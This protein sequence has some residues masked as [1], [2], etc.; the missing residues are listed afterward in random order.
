MQGD[1][2]GESAPNPKASSLGSLIQQAQDLVQKHEEIAKAHSEKPKS[3]WLKVGFSNWLAILGITISLGSVLLAL[4]PGKELLI[5]QYAPDRFSF[6][7]TNQAG[8]TVTVAGRQNSQFFIY[9]VEIANTGGVAISRDDFKDG[10]LFLV[11]DTASKVTTTDPLLLTFVRQNN[12]RQRNDTARITKDN[13]GREGLEYVPQIIN[14]G[15]HVTFDIYS[16]SSE[17][18]F[19]TE[20][21]IVDGKIR[22]DLKLKGP[23]SRPSP[24]FAWI[25]TNIAARRGLALL[26]G[27]GFML[28]A[29]V[30]VYHEGQALFPLQYW[31]E[32]LNFLGAL[33]LLLFGLAMIGAIA[34]C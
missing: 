25:S 14:K 12:A 6:D 16:E 7:N 34:F 33:F 20:G 9:R 31:T 30:N 8:I 11:A 24:M 18:S 2:P 1:K 22:D 5:T 28:F 26:F 23:P 13:S 10:P 27:A 29:L 3:I 17:L 21:K 32:W 15:E 19:H 4:K